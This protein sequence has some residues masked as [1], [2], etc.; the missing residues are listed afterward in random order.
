MRIL[1]IFLMITLLALNGWAVGA[2]IE[3][4][5]DDCEG[6]HGPGGV[7]TDSDIPSIAGQSAGYLADSLRSFR[8]WGRPCKKSRYRHGDTSR[9]DTKMCTISENLSDEDITELADYYSAR[10][11]V[12]AKQVFDSTRAA[13]GKQRHDAECES[14]H[15]QGGRT[16]GRGPILA[17]QWAAYLKVAAGQTLTGEHL[18]PPLMENALADFSE[19]EIEDLLNYYASQQE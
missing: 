11:F 16:P 13:S 14:C 7:S 2:D 3:T 10:A 5:R 18:V 9:P 15:P 17:G 1:Q 12:A 19:E 8:E 6:C 4:L